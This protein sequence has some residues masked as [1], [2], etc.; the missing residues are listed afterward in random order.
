MIRGDCF[1]QERRINLTRDLTAVGLA[2]ARLSLPPRPV[3][4]SVAIEAYAAQ[5]E[6]I[7]TSTIDEFKF[8]LTEYHEAV[9]IGN[10]MI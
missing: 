2:A 5:L 10:V 8:L 9:V 1:Y 7:V 6:P 3:N 4:S